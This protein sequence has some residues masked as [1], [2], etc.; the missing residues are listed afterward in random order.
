[1]SKRGLSSTLSPYPAVRM[2]MK[3]PVLSVHILS[4]A[5][6]IGMFMLTLFIARYTMFSCSTGKLLLA[7]VSYILLYLSFGYI[8][9]G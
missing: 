7:S 4:S 9:C 2:A 6:V 8:V 3:H 1:M 5:S